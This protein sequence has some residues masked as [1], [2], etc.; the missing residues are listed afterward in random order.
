MDRYA[1]TSPCTCYIN[2]IITLPGNHRDSDVELLI[3]CNHWYSNLN[4]ALV[5][6]LLVLLLFFFYC[7]QVVVDYT[8]YDPLLPLM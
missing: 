4:R 6:V 3:L 2:I 5:S 8:D 7:L 1:Y